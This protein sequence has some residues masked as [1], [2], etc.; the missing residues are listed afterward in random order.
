MRKSSALFCASLLGTHDFEGAMASIEQAISFYQ[1]GN[2]TSALFNA[3]DRKAE[4][5]EEQGDLNGAIQTLDSALSIAL[6][7]DDQDL[8]FYAYLDRASVQKKQIWNHLNEKD[9]VK[10]HDVANRAKPITSGRLRSLSP[11]VGTAS[12]IRR[13]HL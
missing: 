11:A 13:V 7:S 6:Q 1:K 5:Q 2:E 4:I 8:W 9:F 12:P 10:A 3:L